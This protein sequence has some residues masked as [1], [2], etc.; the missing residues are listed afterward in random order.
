ES[1]ERESPGGGPPRTTS[2]PA[3]PPRAERQRPPASPPR[4]SRAQAYPATTPPP[5]RGGMP[6]R[7]SRGAFDL[8]LDLG[9]EFD[10]PPAAPRPGK[11]GAGAPA[12]PVPTG[13]FNG[14]AMPPVREA[15]VFS[16][17]AFGGGD[18]IP[19]TAPPPAGKAGAGQAG[20]G[21]AGASVPPPQ[22][23]QA[24]EDLAA[25]LDL[26]SS[27]PG[28]DLGLCAGLSGPRPGEA[29]APILG[30]TGLA[31]A[32]PAA[33]GRRGGKPAARS[34]RDIGHGPPRGG[35]HG[36]DRWDAPGPHAAQAPPR[37]RVGIGLL[38]LGM[39]VSLVGA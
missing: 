23:D 11:G 3:Q 27:G 36:G 25:A 7:Q 26:P 38:L 39:I 6:R 2:A 21:Q 37:R 22:P 17:L 1:P 8:D 34:P 32:P 15:D 19:S 33:P 28:S 9:A 13:G 31:S 35:D 24:E 4:P 18:A 16:P 12:R 29:S 10:I 30:L 5:A 20:A 14:L